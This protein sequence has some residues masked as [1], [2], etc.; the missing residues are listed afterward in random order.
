MLLFD[1]DG[2]QIRPNAVFTIG[3]NYSAP[4]RRLFIL[5]AEHIYYGVLSSYNW[6]MII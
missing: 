6:V 2:L 3:C 4:S 5:F 1:V